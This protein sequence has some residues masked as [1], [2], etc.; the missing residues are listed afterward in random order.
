M[1]R[2]IIVN[3]N[4]YEVRETNKDHQYGYETRELAMAALMATK[5]ESL[6]WQHLK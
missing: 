1:K 4:G 3:E 2:F 5:Q 6:Q